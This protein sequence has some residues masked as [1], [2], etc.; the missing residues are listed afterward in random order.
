MSLSIKLLSLVSV[1]FYGGSRD[2]EGE[3]SRIVPGNLLKER[4][5]FLGPLHNLI[6]LI[7]SPN[8]TVIDKRSA[9]ICGHVRLDDL[10]V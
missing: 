3:T 7:L 6:A 2:A 8:A 5:C 4:Y 9:S 1:C 10:G